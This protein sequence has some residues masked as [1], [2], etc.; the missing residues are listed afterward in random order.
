MTYKMF[1]D[2]ERNPPDV[3]WDILGTKQQYWDGKPWIVCRTMAEVKE[4]MSE[5]GFPYYISF[6]HDLGRE[7][8]TGYDIVKFMVGLLMDNEN[9]LPDDFSF[10][11][12][13]KNPVGANN[14]YYYLDNYMRTLE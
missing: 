8:P 11:V 12:H 6:D 14:I 10:G 5:N 9:L 2:D 4:V 3:K 7:E 13:S 1:I